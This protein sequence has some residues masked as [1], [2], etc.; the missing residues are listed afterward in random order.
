MTADPTDDGATDSLLPAS[1]A[2][3][4]VEH[5]GP[6]RHELQELIDQLMADPILPLAIWTNNALEPQYPHH[7]S[8]SC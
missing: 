7:R 6:N 1:L 8:P 5:P 2:R 3:V 4:A